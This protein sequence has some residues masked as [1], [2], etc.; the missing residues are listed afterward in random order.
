MI[1]AFG[2]LTADLA[3]HHLT[4]HPGRPVAH[5][6]YLLSTLAMLGGTSALGHRITV[7]LLAPAYADDVVETRIEI[8]AAQAGGRLGVLLEADFT[9]RDQH[10]GLIGRGTIGCSIPPE[11]PACAQA[12]TSQADE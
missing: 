10:G 8:T 3:A 11:P 9:I 7:E 12:G 4:Q 6:A 1:S 2:E 5:G